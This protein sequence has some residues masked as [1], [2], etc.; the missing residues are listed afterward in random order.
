MK[1]LG[2]KLKAMLD[3]SSSLQNQNPKLHPGA[4]RLSRAGAARP[5]AGQSPLNR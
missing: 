2:D 3:R 4:P 5:P 1:D